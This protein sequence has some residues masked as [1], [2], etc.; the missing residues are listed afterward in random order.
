MLPNIH[1][2]NVVINDTVRCCNESHIVHTNIYLLLL[3]IF[4]EDLTPDRLETVIGRPGRKGFYPSNEKSEGSAGIEPSTSRIR[5]NHYSTDI[6]K[7]ELMDYMGWSN[8]HIKFSLRSIPLTLR[9]IVRICKD[10]F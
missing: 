3:G 10:F 9:Y 7:K 4:N 2:L 1:V 5:G 8:F 6:P